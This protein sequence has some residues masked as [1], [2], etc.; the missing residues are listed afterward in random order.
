M[1]LVKTILAGTRVQHIFL[2][3]TQLQLVMAAEVRLKIFQCLGLNTYTATSLLHSSLLG[4]NTAIC[5]DN[6]PTHL[7]FPRAQHHGHMSVCIWHKGTTKNAIV[8]GPNHPNI[9]PPSCSVRNAPLNSH[10][11]CYYQFFLLMSHASFLLCC[12]ILTDTKTPEICGFRGV[13]RGSPGYTPWWVE[14]PDQT[15]FCIGKIS[16]L[17][18]W[19]SA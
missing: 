17:S 15:Y 7:H 16:D 14:G 11:C 2:L 13:T 9:Q 18:S 5:S 1:S 8:C 10:L 12:R 6:L 4:S 19:I 3:M